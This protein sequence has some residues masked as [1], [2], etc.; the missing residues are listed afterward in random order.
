M[1]GTMII[2]HG[3]AKRRMVW[4]ALE[5]TARSVREGVNAEIAKSL[6]LSETSM[7][8]AGGSDAPGSEAQ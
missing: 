6:G 1:N 7:D 5:T 3:N 2:T 8:Q 4:Y